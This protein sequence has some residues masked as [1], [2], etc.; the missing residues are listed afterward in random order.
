MNKPILFSSDMVKALLAGTKTQTRRLVKP[1]PQ[2]SHDIDCPYGK[3]GDLLWVRETWCPVDDSDFDGGEWID[4]RAT[5]KYEASHPAGWENEPD[6]PDALKWRPSIH[7]PRWASRITLRITDVRVERLQEIS[8]A[9]AIAEGCPAVSL[10][11]LDC[12]STPPSHHFRALWESINGKG[13]WDENPWVWAI[14]FEVIKQNVD[15]V[16]A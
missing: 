3:P 9:D 5:P 11:S 7:M 10:Y 8:E 6:S 13:S 1:Q 2:I 16:A 4:Y 15:E 14:T 12:E